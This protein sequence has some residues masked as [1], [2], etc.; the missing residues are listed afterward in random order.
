MEQIRLFRHR[1]LPDEITELKD[2][3][4]LFLSEDVL[5]TKWNVL[6]PRHDI[7]NGVSAYFMS[8]GIKVSKIYDASQKLVYWYCDIIQTEE[9]TT[10]NAYI[11]HDLLID[12]LIFPNGRVKVVDMDEFADMMEKNILDKQL[13][14]VALRRTDEL[15][16]LIYSGNFSLLTD[17]IENAEKELHIH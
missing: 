12:V 16:R 10:Q 9:D 15:L 5:I 8:K 3:K 11:F 7:S 4:I 2:D 13:C 14:V 17:Y 6:K 1:F